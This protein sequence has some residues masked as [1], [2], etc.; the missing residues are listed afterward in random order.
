MKK[1]VLQGNL[2]GIATASA[3]L[4]WELLWYYYC[5][6]VAATAFAVLGVFLDISGEFLQFCFTGELFW[7]FVV[8]LFC[9]SSSFCAISIGSSP[10]L[11]FVPALLLSPLFWIGV[12]VGLSALFSWV[13][14]N[15]KMS[16]IKSTWNYTAVDLMKPDGTVILR[17]AKIDMFKGSM[18]LAVD[19][20]GRVE[21]TEPA[22]FTVKDDNNLSLLKLSLCSVEAS[23]VAANVLLLMGFVVVLLLCSCSAGVANLVYFVVSLTVRQGLCIGLSE[24]MASAGKSQLLSFMDELIP[25][26]RTSLCDSMPEVRE[27]AGLAFSTLY[28]SAGLQ[29][30][31]EIV[32]TLLQALEDDET[33]DTALDGLKQILKAFTAHA[34][35]ALAEVAGPGLDFHREWM[36]SRLSALGTIPLP[37]SNRIKIA[38]GVAKG[39][40]FLHSGPEPVIYRDFKM[41]NILLDSESTAGRKNQR[42]LL[43]KN[44]EKPSPWWRSF[45]VK[46]L[47]LLGIQL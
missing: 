1:G 29:A 37:W 5:L 4:S 47:K 14:M 7:F 10:I 25:A 21:V 30:I 19:K 36:V 24:V 20:W 3:V 34:L 40:A 28:K 8:A 18:R 9:F 44:F 46:Q 45:K 17:N 23:L 41:S 26:I 13:A 31:D 32:P 22:S 42:P 11:G 15:L 39:L 33:S 6:C 35:G 27:S 38:L 43:K 12:G 16:V 2:S